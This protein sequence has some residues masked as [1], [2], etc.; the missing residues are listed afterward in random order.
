MCVYCVG[1]ISIVGY[2]LMRSCFMLLFAAVDVTRI[3]FAWNSL[4][5]MTQRG[6]RAAAVCPPNDDAVAN[7]AV[8]N[9]AASTGVSQT[10]PGLDTS[11]I[12]VDYLDAAGNPGA[13]GVNIRFVKVRINGY[14]FTPLLLGIF[15]YNLPI[16]A[17]DFA[18]IVPRESLG[19]IPDPD[20]P[21]AAPVVTP[22][23]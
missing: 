14:E 17:P 11:H 5:D 23:V 19:E 12:A 6:A 4:A 15:G 1:V 20:N 2:A 13:V 7:I 10:V 22:C 18:A 8:F 3:L 9:D 16:T 21:A